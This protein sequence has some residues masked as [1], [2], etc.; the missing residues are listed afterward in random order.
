[1]I[2]TAISALS[3]SVAARALGFFVVWVILS[4][5]GDLFP[6]VVAVLAATGVSLWLL[7]AGGGRARPLALAEFAVRFLRQS[8][9]AGTDVA[10]RALDP[11]LP[12][13][14]GFVRYRVRLPRG[15]ARNIFTTLMSLLPGTVP[16]GPDESDA[17]IIHCLDVGQPVAAQLAA[18]EELVS[19]A[20]G[21]TL[22]N[23]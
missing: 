14:P 17:L 12:I 16:I 11:R 3:R 19:R 1:M 6:G 15:P 21:W 5:S 22:A 23:G 8:M 20:V 4:R 2:A 9:I 18:E 13:N 7:P 10:R